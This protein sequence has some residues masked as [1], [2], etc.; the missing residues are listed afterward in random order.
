MNRTNVA[1]SASALLT[2]LGTTSSGVLG[3]A[4]MDVQCTKCVDTTD[5]QL[6]AVTGGRLRD[7]SVSTIKIQDGAITGSKLA[8]AA[9]TN[10]RIADGAVRE[11]RIADGAVT[12]RKLAPG[13]V[14]EGRIA[15]GAVTNRKLAPGAVR[16]GRLA[17]GAVTA[18]KLAA[19]LQDI[20]FPAAHNFLVLLFG[21]DEVPSVTTS[22]VGRGHFQFAEDTGE[23]RFQ[24]FVNDIGPI[25]G[26][27]IHC[28]G[29]GVNGAVGVTLS[30]ASTTATGLL[31]SGFI[32]VPD[33]G[34]GC[35]WVD[36]QD[37]LDDILAGAAYVN[38]HT[39]ANGGGKIRGQLH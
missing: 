15:D 14:R 37:I 26:A 21:D 18:V 23:L 24:L 16:E 12:N 29:F 6:Q 2:A 11:G 30:G 19:E 1:I 38:V 35:G 28:A 27:H 3:Q 9:V 39:N 32:G 13:A 34:N 25:T 20:V 5:I 4:A 33:N 8:P 7:N 22:A 17:N 31:N 10:S 36:V